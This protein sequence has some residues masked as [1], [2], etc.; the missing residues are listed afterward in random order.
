[1]SKQRGY[2][3]V[4]LLIVIACL[5]ISSIYAY[6]QAKREQTNDF[7]YRSVD[8][9]TF[10]INAIQKYQEHQDKMDVNYYQTVDQEFPNSIKDL[11]RH[12]LLHVCNSEAV[13]CRNLLESPFNG[14]V[15]LENDNKHDKKIALL[16]EIKEYQQLATAL[17]LKPQQ[18]VNL[19][20]I[21]NRRLVNFDLRTLWRKIRV[22]KGLIPRSSIIKK[23][24]EWWLK[25]DVYAAAG[26]TNNDAEKA[27]VVATDGSVPLLKDWNV[28][29]L[30]KI[31][32]G[33]GGIKLSDGGV[34]SSNSVAIKTGIAQ[35]NGQDGTGIYIDTGHCQKVS[36]DG[37][38]SITEN[39][40]TIMAFIKA[41]YPAKN[42]QITNYDIGTFG[43][44]YKLVNNFLSFDIVNFATGTHGIRGE[45]G[46]VADSMNRNNMPLSGQ[47]SF[48]VVCKKAK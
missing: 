19:L 29:G 20:S 45:F 35:V 41:I 23:N 48:I 44:T 46:D 22:V 32:V 37:Y 14:T 28:G 42:A 36:N 7:A 40:L 13:N 10:M 38:F 6:K 1:M 27:G 47:V 16:Y 39:D 9:I 24:G 34:I 17:R 30:N 12:G 26:M 2:T 21:K 8:S 15:K 3:L 25:I 43:V 31:I 33:E 18:V 11:K 5:S 4:I